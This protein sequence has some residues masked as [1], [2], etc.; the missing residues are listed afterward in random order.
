MSEYRVMKKQGHL[1]FKSFLQE[2]TGE[3]SSLIEALN[4]QP[5]RL[6]INES[7]SRL[8]LDLGHS[9]KSVCTK[10]F[11]LVVEYMGAIDYDNAV[12]QSV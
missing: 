9:M 7:R 3:Q 8:D 1:S 5:L 12:W 4:V 6:I 10:Y 2:S 11:D